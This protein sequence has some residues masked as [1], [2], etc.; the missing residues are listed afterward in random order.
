MTLDETYG[1]LYS[2]VEIAE[3][4]EAFWSEKYK[5]GWYEAKN[6]IGREDSYYTPKE[7]LEYNKGYSDYLAAFYNDINGIPCV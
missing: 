6:N 3:A 5:I 4:T 1:T 2:N 7:R